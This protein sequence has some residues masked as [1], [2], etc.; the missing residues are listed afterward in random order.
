MTRACSAAFRWTLVTLADVRPAAVRMAVRICLGLSSSAKPVMTGVS[1]IDS[2]ASI[3]EPVLSYSKGP[4]TPLID[5]S[6]DQV[7]RQTAARVPGH[8]AL[9]VRHQNRRL[10]FA[11]LDA[12]VGRGGRGG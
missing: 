9:V 10:T 3:L 12:G 2:R 6:I 11:P 4:D 1:G 8:D 5:Q 7:F